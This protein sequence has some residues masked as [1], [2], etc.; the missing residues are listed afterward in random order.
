MLTIE[1]LILFF[2]FLNMST[3]STYKAAASVALIAEKHFADHLNEAVQ[4][5]ESDLASTPSAIQIEII[6]DIAFF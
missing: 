1:W 2:E 6:L 3:L 5:G 4:R